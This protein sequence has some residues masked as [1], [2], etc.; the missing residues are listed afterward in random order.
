MAL[1]CSFSVAL[2]GLD[3]HVVKIEA[4]L[5]SGI[6]G[7]SITG[8]P[9]AALNEARDRIRAAVTNSGQA[10]PTTKKVT[11]GLSPASLPKRGSGFDIALAAAVL[12]AD[13]IVPRERLQNVLMLGE[14]GLDGSVRGIVGVL[15]AV[16]AGAERGFSRAIVPTA[17]LAEAQL[18]FPRFDGHRVFT[19]RAEARGDGSAGR[20]RRLR[21]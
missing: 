12:A 1:A 9:D 19:R 4:D 16:L 18:K 21:A 17:N 15:P 14:L 6:P 13:G 5:A 11:I 20:K 10:W 8:L 2:V 7:L 3:G